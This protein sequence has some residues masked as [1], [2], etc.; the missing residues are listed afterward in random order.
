MKD[1]NE[2]LQAVLD[3]D[4]AQRKAETEALAERTEKLARLESQKQAIE[5]ECEAGARQAGAQA[6]QAAEQARQTGLA[7]LQKKQAAAAAALEARAAENR[8]A[9]VQALYRRTL[10]QSASE[11]N[12]NVAAE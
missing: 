8:E 5:E 12:A 9:W 11:V 4:A 1:L 3:M 6:A 10:D 2:L 7:E